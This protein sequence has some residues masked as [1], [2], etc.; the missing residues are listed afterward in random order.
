MSQILTRCSGPGF[1]SVKLGISW[2]GDVAGNSEQRA[3][4]VEGIETAVEAEGEFVEIG[5]QVLRA[6]AVMD[7]AQ[8]SLEIG[9][10]EVNDR[11]EG[12]GNLHVAPLRDSGMAIIT[13]A[14]L[15]VTTPVVGDDGGAGC[16]STLDESAQRLGAAIRRNGKANTPCVALGSAFVTAPLLLALADFDRAGHENHAVYASPLAAGTPTDIGFVGLD[17]FLG[18][19]PDPILV[20]AHHAG[21]QLVENLKG[22]FVA[23]Q[24]ELPLELDGR[25]SGCM[26]GNQVGRPE[27]NRERRVRAFHDRAGREASFVA[28]RPATKNTGAS[29]VAIGFAGRSAVGTGEAVAP[30]RALKVC[31]TCCLV[32]KQALELRKRTR[33]R[34]IVSLKHVD[35]HDFFTLAQVLNILL[36]VGVCDNR[37]STKQPSES[38]ARN[39]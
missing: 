6:D 3:K 36:V 13:L 29:G 27:P 8:P 39:P 5:L 35:E 26:A 14:Q 16:N 11:Q 9:E 22:R 30:S 21:A 7:A 28:T 34:Q 4:G 37:I 10:H 24:P 18:L 31:R 2:C 23:R 19:A 33:E 12:L 15:R 1:G 25:H 17:V 32:R 20:R 38:M